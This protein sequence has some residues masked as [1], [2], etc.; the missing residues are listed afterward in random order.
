MIKTPHR[1]VEIGLLSTE[2]QDQIL[3]KIGKDI[4]GKI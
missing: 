1:F 2:R 4:F 3:E